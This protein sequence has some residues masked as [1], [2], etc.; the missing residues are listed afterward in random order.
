MTKIAAIGKVIIHTY[1]YFTDING[2]EKDMLQRNCKPW[3]LKFMLDQDLSSKTDAMRITRVWSEDDEENQRLAET[4]A[5]ENICA[6]ADEAIDAADGVMILDE[7]VPSRSALIEKCINAGVDCWADKLIS[8]DMED[9]KRLVQL[10]EQQN[11]RVRTWGQLYWCTQWETVREAPRPGAGLLTYAV[12]PDAM[13][14]HCVHPIFILQAAFG[15]LQSYRP[16]SD[17]EART[18][19]LKTEDGTQVF[20]HLTANAPYGGRI[21]Y[22]TKEGAVVAQDADMAGAF[23]N[24]A[25]AVVDFFSGGSPAYGTEAMVEA[26]RLYECI[27]RGG[28]DGKEISL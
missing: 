1:P 12:G 11:V 15:R 25:R 22:V 6:S 16:L 5:I 26:V 10:A 18:A 14:T 8:E 24:S 4:F 7:D 17:G 20:M 21:D 9:A 13:D 19:L 2:C 23:E 3:M 28:S 27:M